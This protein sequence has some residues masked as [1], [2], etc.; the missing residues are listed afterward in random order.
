V[1]ARDFQQALATYSKEIALACGEAAS[2]SF[3]TRV[4]VV[5][6]VS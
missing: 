6:I 1:F 5:L 2:A 3:V 4:T